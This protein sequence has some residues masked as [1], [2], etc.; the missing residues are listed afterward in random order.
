MGNIM[1]KGDQ[2]LVL[3]DIYGDICT[4]SSISFTKCGKSLVSHKCKNVKIAK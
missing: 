3:L 2:H 4:E 1:K